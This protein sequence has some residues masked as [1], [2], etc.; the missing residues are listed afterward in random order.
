MLFTYP[1]CR[2]YDLQ[3]LGIKSPITSR[4]YLRK[5]VDIAVLKEEKMGKELVF[6][7]DKY[8]KLLMD[9]DHQFDEYNMNSQH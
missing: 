6:I 9:T 5:L 2:S 3:Q 4:K 1:Y 7:H 8:L